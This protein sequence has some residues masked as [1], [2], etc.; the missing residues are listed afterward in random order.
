MTPQ[1]RAA[2]L[3]LILILDYEANS[4]GPTD[5]KHNFSALL[6]EL[7]AEP[8]QEPV[9]TVGLSADMWKGYGPTGQ[10]FPPGEPL[11]TV[12]LLRDLPIGTLLYTKQEK[13]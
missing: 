10:W 1:Q 5:Y 8:A 3:R 7:A 6:R 9:A 2:A 13:P 12:H 11:K 4:H